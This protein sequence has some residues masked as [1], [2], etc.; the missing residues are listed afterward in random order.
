MNPPSSADFG[1]MLRKAFGGPEPKRAANL[2]G[3]SGVLIPV[4]LRADGP[5]LLY[6]KRASHLRAHPGEVAFPGGG[7]EASDPDPLSAALREANE[8][9]GLR[10]ERVDVVGHVIDYLTYRGNHIAAYAGIV[11]TPGDVRSASPEVA[12]I[13]WVDVRDLLD[14]TRY[15]ARALPGPSHLVHYF[16]VRPRPVWG[17]TGHITAEFLRRALG[18]TPPAAPR[19]LDGPE[20]Y[21]P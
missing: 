19:I 15:E 1:P 17:I 10:R 20:G 12:E 8:E 13:F 4:A 11:D 5:A 6:E 2:P 7:V 21:L 9:V 16:R 18:W 14:P 3:L